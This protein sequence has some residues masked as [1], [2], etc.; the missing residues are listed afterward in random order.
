MRGVSA[1]RQ[2]I[3]RIRQ[4]R[5]QWPLRAQQLRLIVECPDEDEIELAN[6]RDLHGQVV[7]ERIGQQAGRRPIQRGDRWRTG[8]FALDGDQR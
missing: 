1:P 6:F 2:S 7:R 4:R 5:V 8:H 3:Q